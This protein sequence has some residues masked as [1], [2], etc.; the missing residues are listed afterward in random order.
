MAGL[1][2]RLRSC[3]PPLQ[4]ETKFQ[5]PTCDAKYKIVRVEAAPTHD[6]QIICVS[7]GGPLL[8]RQG[9]FVIKYFRTEGGREITGH[10]V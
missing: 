1:T 2:L 10:R 6:C 3:K 8:G 4:E 5:C 9:K 7:C